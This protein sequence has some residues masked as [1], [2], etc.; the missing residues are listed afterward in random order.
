MK[1]ECYSGQQPAACLAAFTRV[2]TFPLMML[3][4]AAAVVN[5]QGA[6]AASQQLTLEAQYAIS[7]SLGRAQAIYHARKTQS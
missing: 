2:M 5:L 7:A 1:P 4:T 3:A 6:G